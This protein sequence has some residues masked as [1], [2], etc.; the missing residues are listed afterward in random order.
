MTHQ[1]KNKIR[2]LLLLMVFSLNTMAGFACSIGVNM[3][4]NKNHHG[5]GRH[6][7]VGSHHMGAMHHHHNSP[8]LENIS[9][10]KMYSPDNDCCA[11]QV[12]SF[13]R[14]DKSVVYNNLLLKP[15]VFSITLPSNTID[16]SKNENG[17]T[18]NSGFQ[19]VRRWCA[20]DHT[21]IRIAIQSFQI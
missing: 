4:Y 11:S 14:L 1:H 21:D 20:P 3:G 2:A 12:N 19:D 6:D 18:V 10:V 15:P 9:I 5:Q 8:P 7:E 13:T 17:G 16:I